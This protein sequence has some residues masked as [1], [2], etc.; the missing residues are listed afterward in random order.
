[1]NV[2]V[3]RDSIFVDAA[4]EAVFRFFTEAEAL[5]TWMGDRAIVEPRAGGASCCT[6]TIASWRGAMSR[7][8]FLAAW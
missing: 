6:S 7:S 2:R 5:A 8:S 4:P 3:F 1:M